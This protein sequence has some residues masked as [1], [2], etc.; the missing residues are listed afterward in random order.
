MQAQVGFAESLGP[1][2]SH[3]VFHLHKHSW[4][5]LLQAYQVRRCSQIATLFTVLLL[6]GTRTIE[7]QQAARSVAA[8]K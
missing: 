1:L 8:A 6:E 2:Q 5:P 3:K 4:T 7:P